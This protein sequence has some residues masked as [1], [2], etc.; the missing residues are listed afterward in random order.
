MTVVIAAGD[1]YTIAAA[2]SQTNR[3]GN[4]QTNLQPSQ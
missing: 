4:A 1:L 3:K 2:K